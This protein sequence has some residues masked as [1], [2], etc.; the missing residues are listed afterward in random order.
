MDL[1]QLARPVST[2]GR[3]GSP[4]KLSRMDIKAEDG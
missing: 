1:D 4:D 3:P 2:I